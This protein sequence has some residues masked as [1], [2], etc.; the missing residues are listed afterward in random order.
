M[1]KRTQRTL[2]ELEYASKAGTKEWRNWRKLRADVLKYYGEC[3]ACGN[4]KELEGH[5]VYPR[6]L[7]PE[8]ALSWLNIII[9]CDDCHLRLGHW[10]NYKEYNPDIK[11]H[12][13]MLTVS[14]LQQGREK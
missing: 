8:Y 10:G 12:C 5:H 7:F 3:G 2:L 6:H 11:A 14:R 13:E 4:E 1:K 9:L